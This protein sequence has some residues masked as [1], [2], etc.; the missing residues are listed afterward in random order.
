LRRKGKEASRA[1]L[2]AESSVTVSL[3]VREGV[4]VSESFIHEVRS[5]V[6]LPSSPKAEDGSG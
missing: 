1:A 5:S 2:R 4:R 6:R 3:G